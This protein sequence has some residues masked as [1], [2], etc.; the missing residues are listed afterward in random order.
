[1]FSP[2]GTHSLTSVKDF[3]LMEELTYHNSL[4]SMSQIYL[5]YMK[6]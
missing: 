3:E 1:M 4:Q 5:L 6:E 2:G